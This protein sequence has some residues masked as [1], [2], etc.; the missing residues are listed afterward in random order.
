MNI[1]R[2]LRRRL[3]R[4]HMGVKE[5]GTLACLTTAVLLSS[6]VTATN[7]AAGM[8]PV[9]AMNTAPESSVEYDSLS[10]NEL[11]NGE[12]TEDDA[13]VLTT[14]PN[15]EDDATIQR[16]IE[17][18]AR[19][20]K[21]LERK[22]EKDI[23]EE[24]IA[25]IM[26]YINSIV[27]D[28]N[29]VSRVTGLHPEDY[30]LLTKGTWWEGHEDALIDLEKNKGI[31]AM[32]AI[33][34]STLESGS[35]TS[36]RACSKNNFYGIELPTY[37]SGLYSN[38]QWWGNLIKERYVGKGRKSV[39]TIGPVYC[40]PNREWESFHYNKMHELYSNLKVRLEATYL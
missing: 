1:G 22:I 6:T 5:L 39:W 4:A 36:V 26:K 12:S 23:E 32:F 33:S 34:V 9:V 10:V 27:C 19:L 8:S 37:W 11:I 18:E 40:P 15:V 31:N 13:V 29:N 2:K 14:I 20:Q 30:K 7:I 21:T 16:E 28:P 3:K 38:T 17:D 24:R 35:G 25:G